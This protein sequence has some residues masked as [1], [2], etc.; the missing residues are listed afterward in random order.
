MDVPGNQHAAL[1]DQLFDAEGNPK[2]V[3]ID[4]LD[5]VEGQCLVINRIRIAGPKPWGGGKVLH[6]WWADKEE[7]ERALAHMPSSLSDAYDKGS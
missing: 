7:I 4:L 6:T 3:A 2:Q 1:E 5:G